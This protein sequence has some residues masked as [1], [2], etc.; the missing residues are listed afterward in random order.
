MNNDNF[1]L[2]VCMWDCKWGKIWSLYSCFHSKCRFWNDGISPQK[3]IIIIID[4]ES[5][6]FD[7][8]NFWIGRD[9]VLA[10]TVDLLAPVVGFHFSEIFLEFPW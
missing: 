8:I 5:L 7:S 4:I 3:E 6:M 10:D 1:C 2:S 9:Y